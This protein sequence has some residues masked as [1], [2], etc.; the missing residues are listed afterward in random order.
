[1]LQFQQLVVGYHYTGTAF[2][3]LIPEAGHFKARTLG[4]HTRFLPRHVHLCVFITNNSRIYRHTPH[5]LKMYC[6]RLK[7]HGK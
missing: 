3:M 2:T 6:L 5:S 4:T 7:N 1:M